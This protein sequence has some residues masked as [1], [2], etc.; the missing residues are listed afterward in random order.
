MTTKREEKLTQR[1]IQII[2][3]H[4]R[5]LLRH[6]DGWYLGAWTNIAAG[7]DEAHWSKSGE[8]WKCSISNGHSQSHHCTTAK[9]SWLTQIK[10]QCNWNRPIHGERDAAIERPSGC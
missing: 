10:L 5:I 3:K 8:L 9:L 7:P 1:T 6:E 4:G 2:K